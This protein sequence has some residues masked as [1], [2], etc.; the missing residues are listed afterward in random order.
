MKCHVQE[1]LSLEE[2]ARSPDSSQFLQ[3]AHSADTTETWWKDTVNWFI[4]RY[5]DKFD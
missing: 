1:W 2:L 3:R 4:A 5:E